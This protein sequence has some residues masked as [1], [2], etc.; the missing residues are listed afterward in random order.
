M[1]QTSR[2]DEPIVSDGYNQSPPSLSAD[3]TTNNDLN[4]RA[5]DRRLG[6]EEVA[7]LQRQRADA[8]PEEKVS[9]EPGAVNEVA[10]A[11]GAGM[12]GPGGGTGKIAQSYGGCG[13]AAAVEARETLSGHVANDQGSA[14]G[15]RSGRSGRTPRDGPPGRMNTPAAGDLAKKGILRAKNA[16]LTFGKFIGPGFMIAV[17]YSKPCLPLPCAFAI[18]SQAMAKPL[19]QS[20]LA[21]TQLI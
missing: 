7:A 19:L 12:D 2:T 9:P 14:P 1:N 3:L 10:P 20:T 15:S 13:T 4:G 17:A 5:N 21:T 16:F 8:A 6:R 18:K 11:E